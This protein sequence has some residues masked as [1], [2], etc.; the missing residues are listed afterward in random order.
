MAEYL[1]ETEDETRVARYQRSLRIHRIVFAAALVIL[2]GIAV[3][4]YASLSAASKQALREAKDVRMAMKLAAIESYA[5]SVSFYMPTA[6]DGL[7][8][9]AADK[10]KRLSKREG[11]VTLTAWDSKKNDP[12]SF[13]YRIGHYVVY[14]A[15][16]TETDEDRWE[17]YYNL[18]VTDL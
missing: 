17:V 10:I 4:S 18:R 13:T 8:E 11:T 5:D 12:L 16:D 15:K 9:G 14:F 7:Q 6:S 3:Y 1:T 2:L